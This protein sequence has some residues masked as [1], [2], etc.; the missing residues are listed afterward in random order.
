MARR[1]FDSRFGEPPS[2]AVV[3]KL[4]LVFV[5]FHIPLACWSGYRAIVQARRLEVSSAERVVRGGSAVRVGV[6]SSGRA[7]VDMTLEMIQ[8]MRTPPP[9]VRELPV[10][11]G[12]GISRSE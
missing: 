8:W 1:P 6:V 4:L 7:S 3:R 2:I 5:A 9:E 11:I 10:E 12:H